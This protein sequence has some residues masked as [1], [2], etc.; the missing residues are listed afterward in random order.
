MKPTFP[1]ATAD[2]YEALR[3]DAVT[4]ERIFSADP[5]GAILIVKHGVAG[6]MQR[7]N[8]VCGAPATPAPADCLPLPNDTPL[9]QH[10]LVVVLAGMTAPHLR[11]PA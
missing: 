2:H 10:E 11:P 4:C 8:R 3:R 5:L 7:Y 1:V 6:W 9:W